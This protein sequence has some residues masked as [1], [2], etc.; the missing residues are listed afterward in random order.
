MGCFEN[1]TFW[2]VGRLVMGRLVMGRFESG[3]F[4]EQ[5]I[6]YV[7]WHRRPSQ[8]IWWWKTH[9]QPFSIP[10]KPE[11]QSMQWVKKGQQDPHKPESMQLNPIR[12]CS[13]SL[14][15]RR[16][17]ILTNPE[18]QDWFQHWDNI[19]ILPLYLSRSSWWQ[20][21]WDNLQPYQWTVSCSK[22]N[23]FSSQEWNQSWPGSLGPR[24]ASRWARRSTSELSVTMP[25]INTCFC[26]SI[27]WFS[28]NFQ[29]K[30][31]QLE[32]AT[33]KYTCIQVVHR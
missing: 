27:I 24:T 19:P 8:T 22:Q 25:S 10:R 23:S 3:T 15:Q 28:F 30:N 12:L 13:S 16:S 21:G 33:Q 26:N 4:Q 17:S 14:M 2:A 31:K 9:R 5:D 18:G 6:F 1:G 32:I 29:R 11:K 7:H 20:K